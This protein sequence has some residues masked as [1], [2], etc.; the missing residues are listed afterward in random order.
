VNR[1][2]IGRYIG[3]ALVI[4]FL[5]VEVYPIFWLLTASLKGPTEFFTKPSFALPAGFY[6]KNYVEAWTIGHMGTFFLNSVVATSSALVLI[7]ILSLTVSFAITK[8]KWRLSGVTFGIFLAGILVPVQVVLIPLFVIY[9][10]IGL[11]NTLP[12]LSLI[13]AS[14]GMSVSVF[15]MSGYMRYV[16]NELLEAGIVDGCSVYQVLF[17]IILPLTTNAIVTVLVIQF[18]VTWNDLIFSMTFISSRSLK[19]VQT[20]L[21]YFQ[22][23]YG[24]R[25]WGPIFAAIA[26]SVIPTITLYAVLNKLVIRGMTEG[27]VKG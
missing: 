2:R 20:G 21:L 12:G 3:S 26:I 1:R 14:F 5:L 22:D 25:D 13:Y 19:T 18:F 23:E 17:R 15:L 7:V 24:G 16:P 8:M 4:L 11:I 6:I 27:A 9:R 10:Q